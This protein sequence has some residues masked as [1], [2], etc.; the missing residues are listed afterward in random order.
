MPFVD[1][2]DKTALVSSV[3]AADVNQLGAN[4]TAIAE[5]TTFTPTI[6]QSGAVTKTVTYCKYK[7]FGGT[8]KV[9]GFLTIT[10]SGTIA[11][12]ITVTTPVTLATSTELTIGVGRIVDASGP[13]SYPVL[14]NVNTTGTIKFVQS[15]IATPA[16]YVGAVPSFGLA[17]GD[18]IA[19]EYEVEQA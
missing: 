10:G 2:S 4:I 1:W 18:T 12:A 15:D 19:F 8:V 17:V 14:V 13:A 16:G 6:T 3:A 7:T 9:V 11:N 5:W